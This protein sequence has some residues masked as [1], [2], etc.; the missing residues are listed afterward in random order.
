MRKITTVILF[1]LFCFVIQM[2]LFDLLGGWLT[3][4][5]LLLLSI[6]FNLSFGI[7]YGLLSAVVAGVLMDSFSL[8][9]F[10]THIFLFAFCAFMTVILKNYLY[11]MGSGISRSILVLLVCL[12]YVSSSLLFLLMSRP[13]DIAQILK[14]TFIPDVLLTVLLSNSLFIYF[15][16]CVLKSFV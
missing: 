16:K 2:M 5:L 1:I 11:H 13:V 3:P 8:S 9:P 10:G 7:R 4:N 12:V 6:F 14:V 15:K